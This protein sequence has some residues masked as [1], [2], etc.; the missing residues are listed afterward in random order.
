MKDVNVC[1]LELREISVE[2]AL[3]IFSLYGIK[4]KV[5]FF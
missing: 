5:F 2:F 1:I 3:Y 4:F